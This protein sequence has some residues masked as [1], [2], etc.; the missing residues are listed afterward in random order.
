MGIELRG[1]QVAA[2]EAMR[3]EV[4]AGRKAFILQAPTGSGKTLCAAGVIQGAV[5]KGKRVVFLAPRRE[6]IHQCVEKLEW[7]G[8]PSGIIMAGEVGDSMAP[9]Q[10]ACVPTLHARAVQRKRM[11]LPEADLVIQ[12]ECHLALAQTYRHILE[13]YRDRG[14][15]VIGLTA[16][17][18]RG[19]GKALGLVFE[20]IVPT[21]SVSSLVDQGFLVP[22]T[23]YSPAKPDLAGVK[24]RAGD[25][26]EDQLE[27]AMDKPK[28]IG[29]IVTNWQRLASDRQTVVFA[30]GV[31]HSIHL[32][33]EFRRAGIRAEHLDGKT[34]LDERAA[35]L[36]R[37]ATGDVQVLCNC[38]VLTYGWDSPSV[39]CAVLARPTKSLVLYLQMAGRVLRP[40]PGKDS[41]ALILDHSGVV[42]EI[43]FV[44]DEYPWSLDGSTKIQ[45]RM[46]AG[47]KKPKPVVCP[48]C[49]FTF[50][51]ADCCPRCGWK[52]AA[53]KG[54]VVET[55]DGD[56]QETKRGG[57]QKTRVYTV[58]EKQRWY[59]EL[60]H[61]ARTHGYKDGWASHKYRT[62][63]GVWP[64]GLESSP[65]PTSPE[66]SS[67]IRSQQI[68]WAKGKIRHD[69]V[70]MPSLPYDREF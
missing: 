34:P 3:A 42:Q 70:P 31:Q 52:P 64:R 33:D 56:L 41:G 68:R 61:Y 16:T 29:D 27:R 59:S 66:V 7:A 25:Y 4:R 62:L 40:A 15:V 58:A 50:K 20:S 65:K 19:D 22:Q 12:D 24:I 69:P 32:R 60:L 47:P 26:A 51:C 9:V 6:L 37:V 38:M 11:E 39:S 54:K 10:V 8:V 44:D 49:K 13:T 45:E 53:R 55:L 17:P 48:Q 46:T 35:I 2:I 43:G 14:A 1:Y 5:E 63:L 21:C 23:Y 18:A 67:W 36:R 28:L 57:K 30:S